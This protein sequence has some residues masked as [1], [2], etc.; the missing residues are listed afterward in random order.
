MTTGDP[1]GCTTSCLVNETGLSQGCASC[2]GA[3]LQCAIDNCIGQCLD[4][5]SAACATCTE[6]QCLGAFSTCSG[7]QG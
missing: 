6:Q 2:F 5:G 7:Y 3:L 4:P 1:A